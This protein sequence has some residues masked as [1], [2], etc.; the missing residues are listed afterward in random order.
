MARFD[1]QAIGLT[2]AALM[3]VAE[4][5]AGTVERLTFSV[6]APPGA[7]ICSDCGA[8]CC[9]RRSGSPSVCGANPQGASSPWLQP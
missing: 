8:I 6:A 1:D 2:D 7:T 3:A 9:L 4:R 5:L